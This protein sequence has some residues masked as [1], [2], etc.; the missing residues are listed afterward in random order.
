MDGNRR[1]AAERGLPPIEGHRRGGEV[2]REICAA[3]A[4][5]GIEYL[6]VYAF[7]E[8]NWGR[9]AGEVGAADGSRALRSRDA[10]RAICGAKTCACA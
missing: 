4:K 2:L 7:S 9:D 3:A 10:K 1:W 5:A 8:E 6:T